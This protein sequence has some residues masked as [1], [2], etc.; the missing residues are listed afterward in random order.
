MGGAPRD[1]RNLWP[2][3]IDSAAAGTG[4]VT[5]TTTVRCTTPDCPYVDQERT[6]RAQHLGQGVYLLGELVCACGIRPYDIRPAGGVNSGAGQPR[7]VGTGQPRSK[8]C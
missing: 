4:P 3:P 6:V 2:E 5:L 8:P 7:D 1:V